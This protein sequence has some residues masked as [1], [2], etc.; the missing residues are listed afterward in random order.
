LWRDIVEHDHIG[1]LL[2]A[3]RC[4][5]GERHPGQIDAGLHML[6]RG[7][8]LRDDHPEPLLRSSLNSVPFAA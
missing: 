1:L 4:I 6:D 3:G 8:Q 5:S 2:I 7:D